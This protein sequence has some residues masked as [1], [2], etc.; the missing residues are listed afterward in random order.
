[1]KKK[2]YFR[3]GDDDICYPLSYFKWLLDFEG[4]DKLTVCE[5]QKQDI[6]GFFWCK[7]FSAPMDINEGGCGRS[8]K[9]Y[10]PRNGFN[11][12]CKNYSLNFY[13][14]TDNYVTIYKQPI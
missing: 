1:M 13:E 6:N 4:L 8:C 5:A 12:C 7:K 10:V 3:Y 2:L 9:G 11:G 14:P